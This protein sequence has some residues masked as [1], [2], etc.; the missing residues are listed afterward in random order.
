[1]AATLA[2]S[3]A[4]AETPKQARIIVSLAD[5]ESQGIVPIKASLGNGKDP[6]GNL[7]WGALY[8]AK[9]HFKRM[10]G[11]T[12]APRDPV[13]DD[14]LDAFELKHEAHPNTPILFEA[15]DGGAQKK[16]VQSYFRDLRDKASPNTLVGF[17]GHNALMDIFVANIPAFGQTNKVNLGRRR[18]GAVIACNSASYFEP[19]HE[20]LGIE[21]YVMTRG[22]MAPE[23]YVLEGFLLA[24]LDGETANKARAEA[25]KKY[26]E[27]QKI[28]IRSANRLF[29]V[30]I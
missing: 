2:P 24:W 17:V 3:I 15:W 19:H 9:T 28:S 29:G 16:A 21:S 10:S 14:V 13:P 25:A 6:Q 7:Y 12:V 4:K 30:K 26:A 22:L 27:Y 20:A 5:N 18:K 23:A 1:M 11:W 8:G